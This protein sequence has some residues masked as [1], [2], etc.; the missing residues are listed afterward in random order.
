MVPKQLIEQLEVVWKRDKL[1]V[2]KTLLLIFIP[3][4]ETNHN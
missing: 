4:I 1:K 2:L 3:T